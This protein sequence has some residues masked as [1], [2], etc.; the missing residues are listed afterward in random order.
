MQRQFELELAKVKQR[1]EHAIQAVD[2]AGATIEN[3]FKKKV[4]AIKEKSALFFAKL[5]MKLKE[6]N[7]EV[8]AISSM[9]REW[10]ET[11]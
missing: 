5:E 7:Q 6:N 10:Q 4:R 11:I 3:L 9:F 2:E 1:Y 8:V